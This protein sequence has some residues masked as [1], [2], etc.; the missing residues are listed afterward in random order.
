MR[1]TLR[2]SIRCNYVSAAF[3]V[4]T[5]VRSSLRTNICSDNC[6]SHWYKQW[7]VI[8]MCLYGYVFNNLLFF[9]ICLL[10]IY[11]AYCCT[12]LCLIACFIFTSYIWDWYIICALRE[13]THTIFVCLK[14][15]YYW[16][17]LHCWTPEC[18]S[19]RPDWSLRPPI[20]YNISTHYCV[21]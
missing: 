8:C 3:S 10:T 2:T 20:L 11:I 15:T 9:I 1:P 12:Q 16:S 4:R 5:N 6:L 21:P 14:C 13:W 17:A 18:K 19:V 7:W